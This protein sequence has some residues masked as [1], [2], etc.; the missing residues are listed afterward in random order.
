MNEKQPD[1]RALDDVNRYLYKKLKEIRNITYDTLKSIMNKDNYSQNNYK[2]N[3]FKKIQYMKNI[4]KDMKNNLCYFNHNYRE[5]IYISDKYIDNLEKTIHLYIN[6]NYK[7]MDVAVL[8]SNNL[9]NNIFPNKYI[10]AQS[11]NPPF[12]IFQIKYNFNRNPQVQKP[13]SIGNQ[14]NQQEAAAL[15]INE[16]KVNEFI[17]NNRYKQISFKIQTERDNLKNFSFELIHFQ[18]IF[19][20]K[21]KNNFLTDDFKIQSKLNSLENTLLIQ[22]I[23]KELLNIVQFIYYKYQENNS[24]SSFVKDFINCIHDYD[25]IFHIRCNACKKNSKYSFKEK[26][27]FPPYIKYYKDKYGNYKYSYNYK[28]SLFFHPQCIS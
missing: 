18:I 10:L 12:D 13:V 22:K 5:F 23:E 19:T 24:E 8:M 4:L 28:E 14:N 7:I 9:I 21:I 6:Q 15:K 16:V 17:K 20:P 1:K 25:N 27:F 2:E 11:I 26:T 3:I